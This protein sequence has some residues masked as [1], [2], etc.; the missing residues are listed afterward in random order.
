MSNRLGVYVDG[1]NLYHG[2][3]DLEDDHLKWLNLKQVAERFAAIYALK[4]ERVVYFTATNSRHSS[5]DQKSRHLAYINALRLVGVE[6][7]K[8]KFAD[9][10]QRTCPDCR[11]TNKYPEEKQSDVNIA[12][13]MAEDI[14]TNRV[15][16]VMAISGD[17][18]QVPAFKL[19]QRHKPPA[20]R[21]AIFPPKRSG[22][23]LKQAATDTRS[24]SYI[25][26][27]CCVFGNLVG[28]GGPHP[29]RRPDYYNP[30]EGWVHP[31]K[32]PMRRAA[33]NP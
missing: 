27:E 15:D 12:L 6:T 7:V 26:L 21:I 5:T 9:D 19:I 2:V 10:N 32:R 22:N 31:S 33:N 30:P 25:D 23:D 4:V 3:D 13:H 8:G 29:I 17:S 11:V 20:R 18:D 24:I 16:H 14:F 1:F 28:A